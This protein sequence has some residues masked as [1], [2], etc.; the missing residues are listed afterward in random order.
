MNGAPVV[1]ETSPGNVTLSGVTVPAGLTLNANGTVAIAANTPTGNYSLTYKICEISNPTNCSSVTSTIVVSA[2]AA[3]VDLAT[4]ILLSPNIMHG[5]TQFNVAVSLTE[6]L[7][8]PTN[9][10]EILVRMPRDPRISFTFNQT[11]AL[12]GFSP[13]N[14]SVWTYVDTDPNY[15][16]F[17]P[18]SVIAGGMFSTFGFNATFAPGASSG[19]FTLTAS[20]NSGSGGETN[21]KN[22]FA[23]SV[24]DYFIN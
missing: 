9:G 18:S 19:R 14:N 24:V 1:I 20:L 21:S 15:Y 12:I 17:K 7:G 3:V 8:N 4:T 13:V 5:T 23:A 16:I 10:S 2:P 6:L 22:N 11:A